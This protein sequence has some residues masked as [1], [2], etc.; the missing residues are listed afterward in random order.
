[1]IL[2]NKYNIWYYIWL[3]LLSLLLYIYIIH[4]ITLPNIFPYNTVH[5]IPLH[6]IHMNVQITCMKNRKHVYVYIYIFIYYCT[7][8]IQSSKLRFF[9]LR[10]SLRCFRNA[11]ATLRPVQNAPPKSAKRVWTPRRHVERLMFLSREGVKFW[12]WD[13]E[14]WMSWG[15]L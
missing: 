8:Y 7:L 1:M 3:L 5:S 15:P 9:N 2:Y 4:C 13:G 11:G 10:S 14:L 6:C 12:S